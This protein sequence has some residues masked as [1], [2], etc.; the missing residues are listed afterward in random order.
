[1][2]IWFNYDIIKLINDRECDIMGKEDNKSFRALIIILLLLLAIVIAIAIIVR[3]KYKDNSSNID[4]NE[5]LIVNE[6]ENVIK[7]QEKDGLTFDNVDL[8]SQNNNSYLTV[9]VT[10]NS[11]DDYQVEEIHIFLKDKNG[12]YIV[13]YT[14]SDGNKIN[15]LIGYVG[16]T[17]K[18]GESRTVVATIDVN[19]TDDTYEL[20]YEVIK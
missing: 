16:D 18:S 12:D 15:Y 7:K 8:I 20:E 19:I 10:N 1:M 2:I 13:N 3:V 17:I 5:E 4:N 14:S 6:N 9:E 11:S